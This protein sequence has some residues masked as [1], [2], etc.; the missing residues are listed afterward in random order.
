[1]RIWTYVTVTIVSLALWMASYQIAA[2]SYRLA[3]QAGMLPNLHVQTAIN[4][5]FR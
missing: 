3:D 2:A 1:M 5:L 4:L